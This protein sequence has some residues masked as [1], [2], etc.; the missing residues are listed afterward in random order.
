MKE[1]LNS[2]AALSAETAILKRIRSFNACLDRLMRLYSAAAVDGT[3]F[4]SEVVRAIS[5]Q[6]GVGRVSIW[7]LEHDGRYL[8]C[9]VLY[10]EPSQRLSNGTTLL[11]KDYPRYFRA[12]TEKRV[13][14]ANDAIHDPRTS[15]F[16]DSYLNPLRIRSMLDAQIRSA[17]GPR[18]VVCV[19]SV[20]R[21]RDW[22][23]DEIAFVASAAE[24]IGFSLDR[25]DNNFVQS[26]LAVSNRRLEEAV[27]QA[28]EATERYDLAMEASFDGVWDWDLVTRRAYLSEQNY[29]LLGEDPDEH[30]DDV[31]WLRRRVHKGDLKRVD[32]A[33]LRHVESGEPFNVLYRIRH[34]DGD[35]RWW[36]TKGIALQDE[37]GEPCRLVGTNSDVTGLIAAQKELETRNRQLVQAKV[38]IEKIAHF[39]DLT[40]LP[41][42][43]SME[44]T[45]A[46]MFATAKR[47]GNPIALLHV[48]LDRFKEINDTMG[49]AAGDFF[50]RHA[51]AI[52]QDSVEDG[53]FVA[54]IGGDEFV[55]VLNAVSNPIELAAFTGRLIE[56]LSRSVS[57]ASQRRQIGASIGIAVSAPDTPD[58]SHLHS[59]ADIALYRAKNLGGNRA[60]FYSEQMRS[61]LTKRRTLNDELLAGLRKGEFTPYF[62]PQFHAGSLR[63]AGVEA[64]ARWNHPTR[65][66]LT[67]F[68]F[69]DAARDL[70]CVA[71]IDRQILEASVAAHVA[72]RDRGVT[73]PR[74][75]VN[76]SGARLTEPTLVETV[77]NLG[78]EKGFLSFELLE[79]IFFDEMGREAE[80]NLKRLK[81]LGVEI[82]VDDFGT[83]YASIASLVNIRPH[84]LKIDR[85]LV[86][87]IELDSSMMNLVR[88][89]VDIARSLDIGVTAE[90]VET[91][92]QIDLLRSAGC[93]VLQGFGLARPMPPEEFGARHETGEWTGRSARRIAIA[94]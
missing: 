84:R 67:P 57:Y 74:L 35:W 80:R 64:L 10:E 34:G 73:I 88:S 49:H 29:T 26:Q 32:Q 76:V 17:T 70:D 69:L 31:Q 5:G 41:N 7:S 91:A 53:D 78:V 36:R 39:D 13:I 60:E 2:A 40:G 55:V 65:G 3:Q 18:G 61:E 1:A 56:Q 90:G 14:D 9:S 30:V 42:R 4:A 16:A 22:T 50:L 89:I 44:Q 59:N 20:D 77:E 92:R 38:E 8:R 46:S 93:S 68:E 79:S 54:R 83:G 66:V 19:E 63:L 81:E 27:R 86:R 94:S 47:A 45:C 28:N 52:L 72:L 43:R 82:E 48:D 37:N 33:M 85:K 51:A 75:S 87:N 15:E 21:R 71:E 11:S 58:A 62:Q 25:D 23:P 6:L 12:L 24:L